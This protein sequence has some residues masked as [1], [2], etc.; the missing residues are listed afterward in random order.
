MNDTSVKVSEERLREALRPI[1]W[2]DIR[3][4]IGR[5]GDPVDF[6]RH[7]M[8]VFSAMNAIRAKRL[9][10]LHTEPAGEGGVPEGWRDITTAPMTGDVL[11][12]DVETGNVGISSYADKPWRRGFKHRN[13]FPA[14]HWSPLPTLLPV[15]PAY[16]ERAFISSSGGE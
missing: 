9:A 3:E 11:V 5:S 16:R 8:E 10:S 14:T 4:E 13:G 15:D 2:A 7:G 6:D 12:L 1:T